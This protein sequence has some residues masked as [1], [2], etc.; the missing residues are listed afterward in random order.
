[1][2]VSTTEETVGSQP[3]LE[4]NVVVNCWPDMCATVQLIAPGDAKVENKQVR[5]LRKAFDPLKK[6]SIISLKFIKLNVNSVRVVVISYA[7][8]ANAPG[9]K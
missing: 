2:E 1:M 8:F 9:M 7:M 5:S 3:M 4:Q 6:A